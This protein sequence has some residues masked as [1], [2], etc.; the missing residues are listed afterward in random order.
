MLGAILLVIQKLNF[1]P[2]SSSPS[3]VP[4]KYKLRALTACRP[5]RLLITQLLLFIFTKP[6]FHSSVHNHAIFYFCFMRFWFQAILFVYFLMHNYV[7][8][9]ARD[10]HKLIWYKLWVQSLLPKERKKQKR[11]WWEY[12][13]IWLEQ[14]NQKSLDAQRLEWSLHSTFALKLPKK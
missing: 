2:Q 3:R 4:K 5:V 10:W 8:V 11:E 9:V 1:C 14:V 12:V 13:A 7:G 6:C